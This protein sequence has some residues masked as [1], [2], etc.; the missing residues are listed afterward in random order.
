MT[1]ERIPTH[2]EETSK[3]DPAAIASGNFLRDA[4]AAYN[5]GDDEAFKE[6]AKFAELFARMAIIHSEPKSE[7]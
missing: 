4:L 3:L 1:N 7:S 2:N 6:N 5:A